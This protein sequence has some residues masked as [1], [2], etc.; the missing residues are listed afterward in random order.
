MPV[1]GF[2]P[3]EQMEQAIKGL[4]EGARKA[5][6]DPSKVRA[7][8][9]TYPN[10][11]ESGPQSSSSGQQRFPM[12]GTIDQIGSDIERIKAM[13]GVE[14]IIFGYAFS[15]VGKDVKKMIELTKQFAR[16]AR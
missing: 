13:D 6:R 7:F 14:H 11:T 12:S 15:Q 16:F 10:V 5:N 3:L 4:K 2:G 8:V 9:L 1:A